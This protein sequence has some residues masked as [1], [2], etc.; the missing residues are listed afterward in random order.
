MDLGETEMI[1]GYDWL[2]K[3]NPAIDWQK[4]TVLSREP[5]HKVAGVRHE[6]RPTNQRA[7]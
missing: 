1:I 3:H 7:T 5:V 4:K 2:L 6:T